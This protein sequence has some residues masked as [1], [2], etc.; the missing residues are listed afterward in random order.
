MYGGGKNPRK[1]KK[2][3][4]KNKKQTNKQTKKQL[5]NNIIK[6]VRNLL[7]LQKQMKQ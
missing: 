6:K 7:K 1:P 3:K 2:K 4:T 5:E